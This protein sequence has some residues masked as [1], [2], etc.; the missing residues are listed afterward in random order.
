MCFSLLKKFEADNV[1]DRDLALSEELLT[2]R[3]K[4]KLESS[5]K[6]TPFFLTLFFLCYV[7]FFLLF[8]LI[9]QWCAAV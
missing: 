6:V 1:V 5:Y 7:Y 9:S 2:T 8:L 4:D 3:Y